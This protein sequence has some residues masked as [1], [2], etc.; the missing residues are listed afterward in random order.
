MRRQVI[1]T[2]REDLRSER[3]GVR[4]PAHSANPSRS[5]GRCATVLS[6]AEFFVFDDMA[7]R[8]ARF[9]SFDAALKTPSHGS[10]VSD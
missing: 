9:G 4:K 5:S 6:Q 2:P 10:M 1:R 3:S 8:C 7:I